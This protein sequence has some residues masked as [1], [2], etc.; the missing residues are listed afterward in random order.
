MW[1]EPGPEYYLSHYMKGGESSY[2]DKNSDIPSSPGSF[3]YR[4][5]PHHHVVSAGGK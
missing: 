2:H 4:N 5:N 1:Y 3:D